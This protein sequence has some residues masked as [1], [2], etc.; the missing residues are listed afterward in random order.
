MKPVIGITV[1]VEVNQNV[2]MTQQQVL[3]VSQEHADAVIRAGGVPYYLPLT[4]DPELIKQ[5]TEQIDGL[6]LTGGWDVDPMWYQE[7]PLPQLG[8]ISPERDAAEMAIAQAFLVANK[9]I[10]GICRGHQVLAITLG[11]KLYQ[12]ITSQ[13]N[14][15][16]NHSPKM[17][18]NHPMHRIMI[19][20]DSQLH[21]I[22]GHTEIRVNS[23]HHQAIRDY[24][25]TV[26]V[27]AQA[28]DQIIEA[29]EST[30]YPNVLSVQWHPECMFQEYDHAQQLFDWLVKVSSKEKVHQV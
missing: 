23:M 14:E 25:D 29:I 20:P 22:I 12:D 27:T 15:A 13:N 4:T 17:P 26:K 2:G 18:R 9:P 11:C 6:L 19:E 28:E 3:F 24:P 1:S 10:F 21:D 8:E 7:N 30:L 5:Y 16:H